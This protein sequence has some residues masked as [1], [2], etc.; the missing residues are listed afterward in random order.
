MSQLLDLSFVVFD[1]LL[2]EFKFVCLISFFQR[3]QLSLQGQNLVLIISFCTIEK[4]LL[5]IDFDG[6]F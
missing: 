1:D 2:P 5:E 3:F 4:S 6:D